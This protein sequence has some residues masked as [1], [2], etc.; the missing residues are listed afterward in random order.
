LAFGLWLDK[1]IK[2]G[3]MDKMKH[4]TSVILLVCLGSFSLAQNHLIFQKLDSIVKQ[5]ERGYR[6]S[7]LVLRDGITWLSFPRLNRDGNQG[8]PVDNVLGDDAGGNSLILPGAYA[9]GDFDTRVQNDGNMDYAD[10]LSGDDEWVPD[11]YLTH[12]YS[13]Y[14]YKI[15]LTPDQDYIRLQGSMLDHDHPDAYIELHRDYDDNWTGYWLPE[16]QDPFDAI[17]QEV[18]DE[19][20]SFK[21]QTWACAKFWGDGIPQPYWYCASQEHKIELSYGDMVVMKTNSDRNFKWN[22][23]GSSGDD[24]GRSVPDYYLYSEQS[25]YTS[26]FV[27]LDTTEMPLEIGA[28]V[29]DS[30]VGACKVLEDDTMVLVPAYTQGISGDITLQ[31]YYGTKATPAQKDE[32]YVSRQPSG[33]WEKRSINTRESKDFYLIS[34]KGKKN[35]VNVQEESPFGL[36]CFPNP[37]SEGCRI[38]YT[39]PGEQHVRLEVHDIYGNIIAVIT[40][41]MRKA[42]HYELE[43]DAVNSSGKKLPAGVYIIQ[44]ITKD[45]K[46]KAKIVVT[47]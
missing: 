38:S 43:W 3:A 29:G 23:Y 17:P 36:S 1:D 15:H 46:E 47:G 37:V 5:N 2:R 21:S 31:E 11:P 30:C 16:T 20:T 12:V 42:G 40:D 9:Y 18:L 34:L 45:S 27:E 14:G 41:G 4:T 24:K 39:L 8:L 25:D 6:T 26:L 7:V 13:T 19:L 22:R 44:L 33:N 35:N 32:Y 28:F 10:Y